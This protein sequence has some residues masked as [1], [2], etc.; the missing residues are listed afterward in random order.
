MLKLILSLVLPIRS[1]ALAYIVELLIIDIGAVYVFQVV[2][3][4]LY[5]F[6]SESSE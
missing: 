5:S 3:S 2:P 1:V 4:K 6:L